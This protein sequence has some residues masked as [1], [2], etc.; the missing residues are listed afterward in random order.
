[1][2]VCDAIRTKRAV[3]EF[4]DRPIPEQEVRKILN[5]GRRSQS[6]KNSQPWT[7]IAIQDREILAALSKTGDW[8]GHLAGA[9]LGV[10]I[11]TPD[12]AEKFQRLFDAGQCAAYMQL[13]ALELGIGSCLASIY[14]PDQA[15]Q[16]LG[17]PADLHLRIAISFGYP[18][19]PALLSAPPRPGG[20][21]PLDKVVH[22]DRWSKPQP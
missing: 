19:Y 13:A 8:A 21:L 4:Q 1:M 2:K 15:R 10:A 14:Q 7:L 17:Y 3:R 16:I 18:K 9:A 20:R 5:A 22:W 6:S 11:L 12:P